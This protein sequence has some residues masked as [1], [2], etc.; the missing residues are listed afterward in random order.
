MLGQ[1]HQP[2]SAGQSASGGRA[3]PSVAV[4]AGL[5]LGATQGHQGGYADLIL[6]DLGRILKVLHSVSKVDDH[7]EKVGHVQHHMLTRHYH[8]F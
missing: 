8:S 1:V 6:K 2:G 3:P 7:E 4:G 5:P